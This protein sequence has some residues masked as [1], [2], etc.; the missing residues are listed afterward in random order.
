M[1]RETIILVSVA[2]AVLAFGYL[3]T[4]RELDVHATVT[5]GE[6]TI[7]YRSDVGA[8]GAPNPIEDTHAKMTR[9]IQESSD[10]IDAYDAS[11]SGLVS[12]D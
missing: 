1:D 5:A 12:S 6:A 11:N 4:K 10:A 7:T 3:A 8:Q 2:A 9:L